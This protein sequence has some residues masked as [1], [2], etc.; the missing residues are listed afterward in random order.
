MII[1]KTFKNVLAIIFQRINIKQMVFAFI[2][3]CFDLVVNVF[4]LNLNRHR[5]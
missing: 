3:K 1:A 4:G 2:F 5:K